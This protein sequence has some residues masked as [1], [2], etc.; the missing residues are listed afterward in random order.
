MLWPGM[1]W[2]IQTRVLV[3]KMRLS[4]RPTGYRPA[5]RL[6]A[7]LVI[8][9]LLM[10]GL[11]SCGGRDSNASRGEDEAIN[12]PSDI[13][14]TET[15]VKITVP[16]GWVA[17]GKGR[18]DSA[19]IYAAYPARSLYT[20]VI[21]ESDRVLDQFDLE[22]NAEQYRWLIKEELDRFE[23]ETR[24]GLTAL[25]SSPAVQYEI[26][27]TVDGVP[28]VYLHT[29]VRGSD[30]YYQI[31]GWTTAESYRENQETLKAIIESFRGT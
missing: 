26:R 1:L 5:Q 20:K 7:N 27:G 30:D 17:R 2:L 15:N 24:T 14:N 13:E 28:V 25:N 16:D 8:A 9:L 12:V 11:S 21:S 3:Q 19:D 18:R 10:V 23:R 6:I 31:V 4:C 29:T 22:N